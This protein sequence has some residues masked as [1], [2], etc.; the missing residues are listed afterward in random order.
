MIV[1]SI[2]RRMVEDDRKEKKV[3]WIEA[4]SV[5]WLHVV[6]LSCLKNTYSDLTLACG[7]FHYFSC[8]DHFR[9]RFRIFFELSVQCWHCCIRFK[10]LNE[11]LCGDGAFTL[12]QKCCWTS[13]HCQYK[14]RCMKTVRVYTSVCHLQT[15][16]I[17]FKMDQPL[18]RLRNIYTLI[19]LDWI[20][21]STGPPRVLY[22][23]HQRYQS[24]QVGDSLRMQ[25]P[26]EADPPAIVEWEKD[27]ES[28]HIGWERYTKKNKDILQVR[29]LELSD[30][31]EYQCSAVNG[32]GSVQVPFTVNVYSPGNSQFYISDRLMPNWA[33]A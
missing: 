20:C 13:G 11:Q 6:N 18:I 33:T 31:G 25:C 26:I 4:S 22:D 30:S 8:Q 29:D 28:I 2:F 23:L 24:V 5:R 15:R 9:L 32:F 16:R 10:S 21:F 7:Y 19:K 14:A 12:R 3:N 1:R 17:E 27:G